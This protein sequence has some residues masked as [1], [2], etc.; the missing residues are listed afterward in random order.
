MTLSDVTR[1]QIDALNLL[2]DVPLIAVDADEVLVYFMRHFRDFSAQNS[3]QLDPTAGRL[4]HALTHLES[5]MVAD[6][7]TSLGL[8]D[9]FFEAEVHNQLAINSAA[10]VL[11]E[12]SRTAQIVVLTNLPHAARDGRI[13]NLAGH[14]IPY[15]V[16]TNSGGK[17][18]ALTE[19]TAKTGGPVLFIDDSA[20]Q[21]ESAAK[22]APVVRRLQLI[23][24]DY[25]A[26]ALRKTD[27]AEA[28]ALDWDT[29]RDWI[30]SI[31]G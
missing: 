23:G 6:M 8:I 24:C 10:E 1:S 3:W 21:L 14:G 4:D 15:P 11:D 28:L 31:L 12:M 7:P 18:F 30:K 25:A 17:G 16:V 29:G 20:A 2:P 13:A 26:P 22:D 27:A 19:L 5:G 9:A